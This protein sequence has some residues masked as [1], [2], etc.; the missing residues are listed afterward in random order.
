MRLYLTFKRA[1]AFWV[2]LVWVQRW[3]ANERWGDHQEAKRNQWTVSRWHSRKESSQEGRED[4]YVPI[5]HFKCHPKRRTR[6]GRVLLYEDPGFALMCT[7]AIKEWGKLFHWWGQHSWNAKFSWIVGYRWCIQLGLFCST[8]ISLKVVATSY[9]INPPN[10]SE[11]VCLQR[12]VWPLSVIFAFWSDRPEQP[13][14]TFLSH[15]GF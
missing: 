13:L 7:K 6:A 2:A 12:N 1:V 10:V 15:L 11:E 9:Y 5:Y 3:E 4:G 14:M 8:L